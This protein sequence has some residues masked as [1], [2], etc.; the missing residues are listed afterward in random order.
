MP[1][2]CPP[3][4]AARL[5]AAALA[6][7]SVLL[8]P[9]AASAEAWLR[10]P[11]L[12]GTMT[13][14]PSGFVGAADLATDA[15]GT[16][17]IAWISAN[18]SDGE[19]RLT[20]IAPDGSSAPS[21]ALGHTLDVPSV[22]A[23]P[24]GA[25][26]VAWVD[27]GD[28]SVQLARIAAD[29]SMRPTQIAAAGPAS[30]V[31]VGISDSGDA[32]VS[33]TAPGPVLHVRRV[34]ATGQLGPDVDVSSN[35]DEGRGRIAV[36]R[37]GTAWVTWTEPAGGVIGAFAARLTAAGTID[38][39]PVQLSAAGDD[40][41]FLGVVGDAGSAVAT[42]VVAGASADAAFV[43]R[44]NRDG[45]VAGTAFKAA[46][47]LD[48]TGLPEAAPASDGGI[49]LVWTSESTTSGPLSFPLASAHLRHVSPTGA[50]GQ[51][52]RLDD[53]PGTLGAV[54]PHISRGSDGTA[55]V[56]WVAISTD[57]FTLVGFQQRTDGT[58]TDVREIAGVPW[59]FGLSGGLGGG[60]SSGLEL[61]RVATSRL[62]VA[63]AAWIGYDGTGLSLGTARLDAI[64]PQVDAVVP[65]T[66]QLGSTADLSVNV[67]DDGGVG[68]VWWEFGDDSGS[69]R[70]A[71]R[72]RYADAGTY[73][74]S[75]TVTDKAGN[76]TTVTR[77]LTVVAP[78]PT[79][80]RVPAAVKVAKVSRKGAKVTVTGTISKRAGGRVTVAYAQKVGRRSL[81]KRA[82]ASIRNG[83]FTATLKLT[84]KLA[85]V[86]GGRAKVKVS[87]AGD[88]D[89]NAGSATRTVTVP[90]PA[91]AKKKT[92]R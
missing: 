41:S 43:T 76:V 20:R 42:W 92:R 25:T 71:V 48:D 17:S 3:R 62:G 81:S 6:L 27:A 49:D 58:T 32:V 40:V 11:S 53:A 35:L 57:R 2:R 5:L 4:A 19:V 12:T 33:W 89:V 69:P 74:V 18:D 51:A 60:S 31:E 37:D 86:R 23:A 22:A 14:T 45:A 13:P 70:A 72:H 24:N 29:G 46:D 55:T 63:T 84:G 16:S 50:L 44:L 68:S 26:V 21:T 38:G 90:K 75:V 91:K 47:D 67:T 8:L 65:A 73:P 79:P 78:A 61:A 56:T 85:K 80:H 77:Q 36:A 1:N 34:S 87:Y 54:F 10:G 83:R 59:I 15:A 66:V 7:L 9:S 39:A 28:G 88:A 82:T 64:A 30:A 52:R